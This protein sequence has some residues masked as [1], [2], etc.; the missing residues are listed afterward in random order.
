MAFIRQVKTKS[1]ATAVQ[2][3]TKEG[4]KIVK[5]NH[6]GS[7]HNETELLA[8]VQLAQ[9]KLHAGQI[10]LFPEL[11]P[12]LK[13]QIK[14]A[15]SRLLWREL[16]QQYSTLGFNRLGDEVFAHLCVARLVEPT[17]KLDSL[18]VLSLSDINGW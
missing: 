2:I 14:E 10:S 8:L 11:L 13:V 16:R 4:G 6:L 18:R 9:A 17:S 1:G 3:I 7:A 15:S 5:V 12:A